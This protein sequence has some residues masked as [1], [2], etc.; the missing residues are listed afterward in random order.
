MYPRS[1]GMEWLPLWLRQEGEQSQWHSSSQRQTDRE[2]KKEEDRGKI[3][4]GCVKG[5][6]NAKGD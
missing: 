4:L 6:K 3:T 2:K 1:M 5:N